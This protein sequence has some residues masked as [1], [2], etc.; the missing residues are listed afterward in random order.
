MGSCFLEQ[1]SGIDQERC[2]PVRRNPHQPP[3]GIGAG[4]SVNQAGHQVRRLGSGPGSAH[5]HLE[6][7]APDLFLEFVGRSSGD[8]MS[9]IEHDDAVGQPL[10]FLHVLG[11]EQHR[12]A[13]SDSSS[14]NCHSSLR[15]RGSRPVV[16]RR[17]TARVGEL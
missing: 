11:R 16:A 7:A 9:V 10:R 3:V 4:R 17:G 5:P 2:P 14:M 13:V 15:V 12:R 1:P 8:D 6:D